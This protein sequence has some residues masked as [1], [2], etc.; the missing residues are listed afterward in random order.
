MAGTRP[1]YVEVA[2]SKNDN[3]GTSFKENWAAFK[4][5][6]LTGDR[7]GH[8]LKNIAVEWIRENPATTMWIC[9]ALLLLLIGTNAYFALS[10][11]C[12]A[13]SLVSPQAR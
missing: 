10:P 9:L 4:V 5:A 2:M 1:D 12:P 11:D 3:R 8:E 7:P 13:A 6:W